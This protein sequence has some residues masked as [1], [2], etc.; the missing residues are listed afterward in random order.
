[1]D[2]RIK[3]LQLRYYR[4]EDHAKK[5]EERCQCDGMTEHATSGVITRFSTASLNAIFLKSLTFS[6]PI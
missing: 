3:M 6:M 4:G 5:T 1:M 2:T